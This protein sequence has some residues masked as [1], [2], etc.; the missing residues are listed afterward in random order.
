MDMLGRDPIRIGLLYDLIWPE[1]GSWRLNDDFIGGVT[2]AIDEGVS[3]GLVDRPVEFIRRDVNGLPRGS[4]KAVIDAWQELVDDGALLIIGPPITENAIVLREHIERGHFVPTLSWCGSEDWLGEWCFALSDGSL[5]EE[6]FYIA[7]LLAGSGHRRVGVS[8]E[9]SAIGTEYLS[10]F[11]QACE[12]AGVE[13]VA[14][15]TIAQTAVE[16]TD[17]VTTLKASS[18]DA[19]VHLGFGFGLVR[20]NE[21]LDNI[22]WAPPRYTTTA[23]ENGFLSDELFAAYR[24]WIGLEHY[25]EGNAVG[26]AVLDR[27]QERFGR[28]PEYA[29]PLYGF[30]VGNIVVNAL[31][32]AEPLSPTGVKRG[33]ERVKMLPSACG[34]AGT[35]ISYGKWKRNGWHGPGYMTAREVA[36]DL[37]STILRGRYDG[38]V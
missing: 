30:D 3:R 32:H 4:A 17:V 36:P 27:F 11:R 28:R 23:W 33:M 37:K 34:S 29:Y 12:G 18:P 13:I 21:A 26:Q 9:R 25:D 2:M 31:S 6:P 7:S 1:P 35:R 38:P 22:G 20:I 8:Y 19:I 24:H 14:T 10:Y 15:A 5:T 16:A